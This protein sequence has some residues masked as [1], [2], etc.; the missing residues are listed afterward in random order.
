MSTCLLD[1]TYA[2]PHY[3]SLV[4]C[5][6]V[7]ASNLPP[8]CGIAPPTTHVPRNKYQCMTNAP[9]VCPA[10]LG[11]AGCTRCPNGTW[12]DGNMPPSINCTR[13]PNGTTTV[14]G[15]AQTIVST[16]SMCLPGWAGNT[17]CVLCRT[18]FFSPEGNAT[19]PKPGECQPW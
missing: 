9:S 13:C 8:L 3:P 16:C 10:G 1:V 2:A 19:N 7:Y 15:G 4:W 6:L 14:Q 17:T 5:M 11:G 12:S 18:G